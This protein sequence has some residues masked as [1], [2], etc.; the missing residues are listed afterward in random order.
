MTASVAYSDIFEAAGGI[1]NCKSV[2]EESRNK[3]QVYN[4]CKSVKSE[5]GQGKDEIF[6]LLSL[7]KELQ[8]MEEGGFLKEVQI[9]STPYAILA[10]KW[11]LNNI[12]TYCCQPTQ[13]SVFGVDATFELGETLTTYKKPFPA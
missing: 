9:G 1:H 6:D 11:Q 8:A 12:V 13:F 3:S 7:L 10:S 5:S 2:S 4:A